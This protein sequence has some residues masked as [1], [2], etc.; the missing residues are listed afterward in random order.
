MNKFKKENNEDELIHKDV[1][2]VKG[3]PIDNDEQIKN[4]GALGNLI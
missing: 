3:E 2:I 4:N 1:P